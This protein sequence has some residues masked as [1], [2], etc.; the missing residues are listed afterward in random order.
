MEEEVQVRCW[1]RVLDVNEWHRLR[2]NS[3]PISPSLRSRTSREQ[4][5]ALSESN[6]SASDSP[7]HLSTK[8]RNKRFTMLEAR[9]SSQ[10]QCFEIRSHWFQLLHNIIS[11]TLM[12]QIWMNEAARRKFSL[13]KWRN[14]TYFHEIEDSIQIQV[15]NS[16]WKSLENSQ[17]TFL[18]NTSIAEIQVLREWVWDVEKRL[19]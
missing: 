19:Q 11:I 6:S 1:R 3:S 17:A 2:N 4:D 16:I 5:E 7:N 9:T 8:K 10:C 14:V 15:W 13:Q 12:I 18:L